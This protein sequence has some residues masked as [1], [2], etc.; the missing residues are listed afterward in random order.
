MEIVFIDTTVLI[1]PLLLLQFKY[2]FCFCFVACN[3]VF[4]ILI[5]VVFSLLVCVI[6]SSNVKIFIIII[7]CLGIKNAEAFVMWNFLDARCVSDNYMYYVSIYLCTIYLSIYVLRHGVNRI[8]RV[9]IY[10]RGKCSNIYSRC[11]FLCLFTVWILFTSFYHTYI[12]LIFF[13]ER[14]SFDKE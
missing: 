7:I 12:K 4:V 5:D 2:L 6:H 11:V 3:K 14:C 13:W 1:V 8:R 10:R 9:N